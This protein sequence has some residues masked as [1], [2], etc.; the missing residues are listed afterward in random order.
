MEAG[1]EAVPASARAM[2]SGDT[3]VADLARLVMW[4]IAPT[5]PD[6]ENAL[7]ELAARARTDTAAGLLLRRAPPLPDEIATELA[8]SEPLP[9][10]AALGEQ[11]QSALPRIKK[12]L[13]AET[14]S[15]RIEAANALYRVSGH[16]QPALDRLTV[17]FRTDNLFLR[18]RIHIVWVDMLR[19]QPAEMRA[20]LEKLSKSEHEAVAQM[21]QSMLAP[22][23]GGPVDGG[24]VDGG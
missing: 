5:A 18:Q 10:L 15:E 17:E 23:D 9:V 22:I 24:P 6:T 1:E 7:R 8:R 12:S 16:L 11:M 2:K 20:E 3:T 19:A 21:A 14:A 4:K 13:D